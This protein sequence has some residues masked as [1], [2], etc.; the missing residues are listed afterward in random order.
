MHLAIFLVLGPLIAM[1]TAMYGLPPLL[2]YVTGTRAVA[3]S[4]AS[5]KGNMPPM[6]LA[7]ALGFLPAFATSRVD[8]IL[9]DIEM[10]TPF[11]VILTGLAAA[12]FMPMIM[13]FAALAVFGN[14]RVLLVVALV[15]FVPGLLCSLLGGFVRAAH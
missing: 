5:L 4:A 15:G 8:G 12:L 11:R 14:P 13:V 6:P 9:H 1:T 10:A 2:E 7:Y 3:Q